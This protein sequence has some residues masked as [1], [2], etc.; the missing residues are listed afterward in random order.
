M[1][2]LAKPNDLDDPEGDGWPEFGQSDPIC[3]PS[4]THIGF[5]ED[6]WIDEMYVPTI[7]TSGDASSSSTRLTNTRVPGNTTITPRP[8]RL[9]RD[10]KEQQRAEGLARIVSV[11]K[12]R[13]KRFQ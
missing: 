10:Q 7:Q 4:L 6:P 9:T 1:P 3:D 12:N 5:D 11:I 13:I 2:I 8:Q